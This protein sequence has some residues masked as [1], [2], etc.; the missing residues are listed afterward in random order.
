[1]G[2]CTKDDRCTQ[3]QMGLRRMSSTP[4]GISGTCTSEGSIGQDMGFGRATHSVERECCRKGTVA[5]TYNDNVPLGKLAHIRRHGILQRM[6]VSAS[7]VRCLSPLMAQRGVAD[8]RTIIHYLAAERA[9]PTLSLRDPTLLMSYDDE[10]GVPPPWAGRAPPGRS[11]GSARS[12]VSLRYS[13]LL[14]WVINRPEV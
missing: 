2:R 4:L 7:V 1:M 14:S 9:R 11:M 8:V 6:M 3:S 5:P 13:V 12:P 10:R